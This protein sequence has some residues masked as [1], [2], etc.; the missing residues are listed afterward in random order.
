MDE[1]GANI[2]VVFRNGLKDYEVLPP[3]DVW[4]NIYPAVRK[5]QRPY[6]ILRAAAMIAVIISLSFLAYR[7]SAKISTGLSGNDIIINQESEIPVTDNPVQLLIADAGN[8][9]TRNFGSGNTLPSDQPE[10]LIVVNKNTNSAQSIEFQSVTSGVPVSVKPE[11][12]HSYHSVFMHADYSISPDVNAP[13]YLSYDQSEKKTE[14]WSIAALISPTYN[15]NIKSGSNEYA[16]QLLADDQ[17]MLSY[18]GGVA[19]SYKINRR[20]SVQSGLYY[21]TFGH[22]LSGITAF[23]GFRDYNQVKGEHSFEVLTTSGTVYT[24]NADIFLST[25]RIKNS[26]ITSYTGDVPETVKAG[27]QYIGNSLHQN[28]SYLELPLILRYKVIDKTIDFNII[29]GLS[30]NLLVANAVFAKSD[31]GKYAIGETDDLNP[32]TFSSSL[33]MGLEYN[34][35]KNLSLNMEPTF[36]YYLNSSN[37]IPGMKLHPYSFGIFSGLSY[38]F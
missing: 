6:V 38:K 7:W 17:T 3:P 30:S 22:E 10:N 5:K 24:D 9:F 36:R 14:R 1:R 21:S 11:V 35:S 8:A 37:V 18:S 33:G 23:S 13:Q 15:M 28:F 26:A 34:L 31:G 32:L 29:G 27:L 25:G 2:D 20:I 19:L 12:R 4:K 16:D